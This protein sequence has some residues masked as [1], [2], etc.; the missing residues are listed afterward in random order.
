M[1]V[2]KLE[3]PKFKGI[4]VNILQNNESL[5]CDSQAFPNRCHRIGHMMES[6]DQA[7]IVEAIIFESKLFT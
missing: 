7:H 4:L 3:H 6:K 2:E 1:I 5:F